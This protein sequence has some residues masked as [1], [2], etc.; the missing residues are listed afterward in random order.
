M[1]QAAKPAGWVGGGRYSRPI[2]QHEQEGA[3]DEGLEDLPV[4]AQ[5]GQPGHEELACHG[6]EARHHRDHEPFSGGTQLYSWNTEG[7][8]KT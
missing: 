2:E 3:D 1:R 4:P 8:R 6:H 5:H 7:T